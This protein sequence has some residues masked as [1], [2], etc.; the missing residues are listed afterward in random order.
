MAMELCKAIG[1]AHPKAILCSSFNPFRREIYTGGEDATIRVWEAESGKLLNTLTEHL[2]WV[3][4]L[5]FCKELKVLFSASVDGFIV[6]WGPSGKILQKIHTESPIYCMAYNQRRQKLL[7]G[8]NKRIRVFQMVSPEDSHLSTDVL[9]RKSVS[10]S[11][12]TDV[13]SCLVA[14]EGRCFSAGYDRKIVIY[15]IPHH[16]DLKLKP[17]KIISNAHDAAISCMVYGKDADNSWLI[18]GSFDRIVKL[19]SL[20]GNLLQ[21][22]DGFS[23]TITSICYVLPTQTLWITANS[24]APVVFDPR[25]GINVSEFVGSSSEAIQQKTNASTFKQLLFVQELNEVIGIT[26]RRSIIVWKY[27][28]AASITVLSGMTDAV[29]CLTFTLKEPLLIFS[30]GSDGL[31]RKWERLQLNTFMYSQENLVLPK[32]ERHEEEIVVN[33]FSKNPEER[34]K[35]QNALH[36]QIT[37]KL[38]RWKRGIEEDMKH[39][40]QQVEL[41]SRDAIRAFKRNQSKLKTELQIAK[42]FDDSA[43]L[44]AAKNVRQGVLAMYYYEDMD[45]LLSGYED[46]KIRAWGYNEEVV[47]YV[48]EEGE[49]GDK[50]ASAEPNLSN[51]SVTNRVSGMTLKYT[52]NDHKDA[53]TGIHCL[54]K[55]GRHWMISTGWDRRICVT[56]LKQGRLHDVFKNAQKGYG[57]EELAAD[58]IILDLEYCPERNE[59]GY[60]SADKSAYIRKFSPK[61]EEMLLQAVLIGHEAE[62]SKIKWNRR[63]QQWVTGSE[64]RSI[65]IWSAEGAQMIN[66][67]NNDGPVSALCIDAINGYKCIRIFDL[68][69]KEQVAQK[70]VGH[71]DEIR[72]VIHIPVRN[73]YVSAS[74]DNTVRIWNAYMKKGQRRV[75]INKVSTPNQN[76][77]PGVGTEH[78]DGPTYSEMNPLMVPKMISAATAAAALRPARAATEDNSEA[79]QSK[80][81]EEELKTTLSDLEFALTADKSGP[82]KRAGH[83]ARKRNWKQ[84][85]VAPKKDL[86]PQ[87]GDVLATKGHDFSDYFLK[88]ELLMG[89]YEAGFEKPSPIQEESIPIAM[90]GRDILARAK[91]VFYSFRA[92][93]GED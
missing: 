5:M 62:V 40:D 26:N 16:G 57:K 91:Y 42:G 65:R 28:P 7:A 53:V 3:T 54:Y 93:R 18:T 22:F 51:E 81:L 80:V 14:C 47:K 77:A 4:C 84:Q 64:D 25:S 32:E 60:A 8:Y 49:K 19:W 55:D 46:N 86:R 35:R 13:V 70:N 2:G 17:V 74:L 39:Q 83:R 30:G 75:V 66:V 15:D 11:D 36:K 10:S 68:E 23:D 85:A 21:R 48:P 56:D 43:S 31:I 78:D 33:S 38:D 69:N 1:D 79:T 61:G 12:H 50:D 6:A 88:R 73:Q 82:Q 29:E 87:T 76:Q 59:F 58:G 27:N 63:Y 37:E 92:W 72:S 45:L 9:E 89:L 41:M 67:I 24:P 71:H 20:D 34:R 90:T 44:N 52:L